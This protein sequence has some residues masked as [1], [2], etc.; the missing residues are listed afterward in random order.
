MKG[1]FKYRL[2]SDIVGMLKIELDLPENVRQVAEMAGYSK[3]ELENLIGQEFQV[4][5]ELLALEEQS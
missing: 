3:E 2:S 4:F 1:K 5:V